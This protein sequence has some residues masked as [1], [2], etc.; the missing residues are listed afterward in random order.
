M[1]R[2]GLLWLERIRY[3]SV[4]CLLQLPLYGMIVYGMVWCCL[5]GHDIVSS[6][7][8]LSA[9]EWIS[10]M[11]E[12]T[13]YFVSLPIGCIVW[14]VYVIVV[15]LVSKTNVMSIRRQYLE[16][17]INVLFIHTITKDKRTSFL[18][19]IRLYIERDHVRKKGL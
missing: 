11:Q 15:M 14:I 12:M 9:I 19:M 17:Q 3:G 16:H 4:V 6:F 2:Q 7:R 5:N 10:K 18:E 8:S 13:D 1:I